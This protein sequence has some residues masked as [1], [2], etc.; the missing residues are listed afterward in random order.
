MKKIFVIEIEDVEKYP[1]VLTV[2]GC[3]S[4]KKNCAV[5]LI[6]I[7]AT[8]NIKKFCIANDII[9]FNSKGIKSSANNIVLQRTKLYIN[10]VQVRK[11]IWKY[12]NMNYKRDDL[13]WVCSFATLKLLGKP[14]LKTKYIFHAFE[15]VERLKISWFIPFIKV[16]LEM[17][18]KRAYK[19]VVCEY[20]RAYITKTWFSLKELPCI[21]PNKLYYKGKIGLNDNIPES[22]LA[23]IES[24]SNKKIILYQGVYGIE[25][26]IAPFIKAAEY[27]D[28]EFVLVIMGNG[29]I[30][31]LEVNMD[32]VVFFP[33][34]PA[35]FHLYVTSKSYIGII[36]YNVNAEGFSFTSSLNTLYCAPN[37]I[38]EYTKYSLPV[39]GNNLPGLAKPI[40]DFN[41]GICINELETDS[42]IGDR[43]SV[44]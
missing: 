38:F 24:L 33:F 28:D 21:L 8:E 39:L 4:D 26:P 14:L 27:L 32:K 37:K 42:I 12:L 3:L 10:Y 16:N 18:L 23:R 5:E 34:I 15:L 11:K 31:S 7:N 44:V 43:K 1:P 22:I 9:L 2:L 13:I 36:C 20:N 41:F 29:D 40:Y 6:T 19:I 35:P 17:Y 25:R 30:N